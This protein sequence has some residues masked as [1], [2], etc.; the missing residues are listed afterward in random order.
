MMPPFEAEKA[1]LRRAGCLPRL[2][3]VNLRRPL[4]TDRLRLLLE[5][6]AG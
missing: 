3:E 5:H 4:E 1:V 6:L 2:L